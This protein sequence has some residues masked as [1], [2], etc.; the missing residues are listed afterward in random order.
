MKDTKIEW[1]HHTVNFWWGCTKVSPACAH[2]YAETITKMFGRGRASWGP[3]G[4]R[5]LRHEAAA[6]ELI[7]LDKSAR[8][9]GVR[10]RVFINSMSDTF[11]DRAD[12]SAARNLLFVTAEKLTNLDILLLTKRPENVLPMVEAIRKHWDA[13][14]LPFFPH[15]W[16]GTTVENQEMAAERIPHLLKIPAAVRFL[17]CEPLLGPV[18]LTAVQQ[19]VAPGFFGDCLQWYHRGACHVTEGIEFPTI[20]WV[21]AGG[22]S[23]GSARPM[24]PDWVNG[25][26]DQCQEAGVPFHFKQWGEWLPATILNGGQFQVSTPAEHPGPKRPGFHHWNRIFSDDKNISARVGKMA[27]GRLL[28]G[29]EWNEFP[30]LT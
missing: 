17:S 12:L 3:G 29:R 2:C 8:K 13:E 22:E 5:W 4:R 11:E 30:T 27:A 15:I 16:V 24:H 21:I 1:C 18:D 23:G 20:S 28:D 9:R 10:E 26:R 25:L 19:T 6:A 14:K 7:K